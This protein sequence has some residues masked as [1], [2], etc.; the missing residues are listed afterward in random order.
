[1]KRNT[2]WIAI[3]TGIVLAILTAVPFSPDGSRIAVHFH[4]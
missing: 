2:Q 4:G 1:M 3:A